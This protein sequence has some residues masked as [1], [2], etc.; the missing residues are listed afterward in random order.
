MRSAAEQFEVN[1]TAY[2]F[3]N[4]FVLQIVITLSRIP[5]IAHAAY[6]WFSLIF[7]ISR[8]LAV[9]LYSADV[10]NESKKPIR[11]LRSCPAESWCTDVGV[12]YT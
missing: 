11:A 8:T 9:S 2:F 4:R 6:F 10:N 1:E 5:S 7:L 12:L 3:L